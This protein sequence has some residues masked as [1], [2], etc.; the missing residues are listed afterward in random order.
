[1]SSKGFTLIEVLIALT[2]FAVF[3]S[4]FVLGQG[5]NLA[6]STMLREEITMRELCTEI[7]NE[8]TSN[9]PELRESLT[10][11]TETKNFEN[12]K[13]TAYKENYQYTIEW[14]RFKFPDIEKI[15]GEIQGSDSSDGSI[16][17]IEKSLIEQITKNMEEMIWQV[18]V[19][20]TNKESN[21]Q[22][23]LSTWILNR[24]AKMEVSGI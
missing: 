19:T 1:M 3:I 4:I 24:D 17:G 20:I 13:E 7:V 22:Y 11:S 5:G 21:Y 14:K 15:T 12:T 2:I 9:P 18:Q 6:D 10:L 23:S 8:I 16:A